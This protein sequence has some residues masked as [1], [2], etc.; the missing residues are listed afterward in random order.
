MPSFY[1]EQRGY[2][3]LQNSLR[4]LASDMEEELDPV[5][6][7][8]AQYTRFRL[9]GT[10][11]PP[12]RPRQT[13]VRT[14]QLANRWKIERHG[15]SR[16][17]IMNEAVGRRGQRYTTYVVGDSQGGGQAW[18]H[19]GRWWLARDVIEEQAPGLRTAMLQRI[20]QIWEDGGE[21]L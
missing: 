4:R 10:P 15:F 7:D 8:W 3:R 1:L 21:R 9:K 12:K 18:M 14:G 16:V 13:Y 20:V 6:Y 19:R 17:S 5:V 2:N 11:Y